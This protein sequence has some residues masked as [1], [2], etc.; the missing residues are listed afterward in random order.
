MDALEELVEKYGGI[1]EAEP[2]KFTYYTDGKH[3]SQ[4]LRARVEFRGRIV[5]IG[6][7]V[8]G[9]TGL[10]FS[11]PTKVKFEQYFG[12][13]PRGYY[14]QLFYRLFPNWKYNFPPII[15]KNYVFKGKTQ[16][17]KK[18]RANQELMNLMSHTY[19][20]IHSR[21]SDKERLYM[22]PLYGVKGTIEELE[23]L[24]S[25]LCLIANE[26]EKEPFSY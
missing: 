20:S 13:Y 3:Y 26:I 5:D 4:P 25:I 2:L 7:N 11:T 24:S 9:G 21:N 16:W 23:M 15:H 10:L 17:L 18:I 12:I 6:G 22:M 19:L 14:A 8:T 1:Y